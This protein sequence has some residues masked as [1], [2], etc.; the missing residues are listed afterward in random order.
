M[1]FTAFCHETMR[2][3]NLYDLLDTSSNQ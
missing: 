2:L 1:S 3:T